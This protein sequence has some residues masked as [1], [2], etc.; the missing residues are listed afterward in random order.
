MALELSSDQIVTLS[1]SIITIITII[2]IVI[3]VIINIVIGK[4]TIIDAIPY[5]CSYIKTPE[6]LSLV[7][8]MALIKYDFPMETDV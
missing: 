4:D 2:I 3:I 6:T 7:E 8:Q 1:S 5:S